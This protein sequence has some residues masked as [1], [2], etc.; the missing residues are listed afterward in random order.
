MTVPTDRA[1]RTRIRLPPGAYGLRNSIFSIAVCCEGKRPLLLQETLAQMVWV[2]LQNGTLNGYAQLHAAVLMSDHAHLL[3]QVQDL[4]LVTAI[5]RWKSFTTK[6]YRD[7]GG[8]GP[9]W[10]R[11]FYDHGIRAGEDLFAAALYIVQNPHRAGM[12]D[13]ERFTWSRWGPFSP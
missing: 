7:Y 11:S 13:R 8:R 6:L 5:S 9:L 1:Q 4:D 10:Q 12:A 2:T 3:V